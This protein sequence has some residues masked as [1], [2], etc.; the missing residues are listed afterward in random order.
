MRGAFLT[1]EGGFEPAVDGVGVDDLDQMPAG[2]GE[3][4]GVEVS[5]LADQDL[6]PAAPDQVTGTAGRR[7]LGR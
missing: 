1:F 6:L 2:P 7:R 4:G 3:L 5:G